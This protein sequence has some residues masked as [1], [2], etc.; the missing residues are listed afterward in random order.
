MKKGKEQKTVQL[1]LW[2]EEINDRIHAED[3][4]KLSKTLEEIGEKMS[5]FMEMG[6]TFFQKFSK[7]E[8]QN[9]KN[10]FEVFYETLEK[11][12]KK[13]NEKMKHHQ[14]ILNLLIEKIQKEASNIRISIYGS[15]GTS[16]A[17]SSFDMKSLALN[18]QA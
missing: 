4:E 2:V 12:A 18:H 16:E 1:K 10:A 9:L 17:L 13:T 3:G 6:P 8:R 7:E 5:F 14:E 11:K 15:Q